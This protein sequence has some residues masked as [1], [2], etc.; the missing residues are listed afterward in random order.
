MKT[1]LLLLSLFLALFCSVSTFGQVNVYMISSTAGDP[2]DATSNTSGMTTVFGSNWSEEYYESVNVSTLLTS[3]TKFIYMDGGANDD[4]YLSSFLSNNLTAIQT[5][6]SNGGHLFLNAAPWNTG[7]NFGF[8]GVTL[9]FNTSYTDAATAGEQVGSNIIFSSPYSP[10]S[11]P[12]SGDYFAHAYISGSGYTTLIEDPATGR[13]LLAQM[14]YGSGIAM[15]GGMTADQ[16]ASPQPGAHYLRMNIFEYLG[17]TCT[18]PSIISQPS[19]VS[20]CP[21]TNTTFS[22]SASGTNTYQ[23]Q[24]NTG[25]GFT[26]ISNAAPYSNATTATLSLT[27]VPSGSSGFQ[28]QCVVTSAC[29]IST[30]S[31]TAALTVTAATAISSQPSSTAVCS[32]TNAAFSVGATGVS[33]SYQWQLSTNNGVSFGNISGATAS[34]YTVPTPN[35]SLDNSQYRVNITGTCGSVTSSSATLRV[36]SITAATVSSQTTCSGT[37][38]VFN[39]SPTSTGPGA[40]SYQW[41]LS[42]VGTFSNISGATSA[43]YTVVSP[44]GTSNNNQYHC[45]VTS[46]SCTSFTSTAGTLTVNASPVFTTCPS[47]MTVSTSTTTCNAVVAYTAIASGTP[48]PTITYSF[49][50]ATSGS[51]SGTGTGST[52]NKGVT[53]VTINAANTCGSATACSFTITVNDNTPPVADAQN[54]I[55]FLDGPSGIAYATAAAVNN[56]SSDNC[57]AAGSLTLS[58]SQT[59]F[60]CPNLGDNVVTLTVTDASGNSSTANATVTVKDVIPPVVRTKNI[61]LN[62]DENTSTTIAS[63]ALDNGSSDNCTIATE[64]I[65]QSMFSCANAGPN[66]VTVTITDESGNVATGTAIVTVNVPVMTVSGNGNAITSGSSTASATNGTDFGSTGI[67]TATTQTYTI[68]NTG[69]NALTIR[70]ISFSGANASDFTV[71]TAPASSVAANGA[72]T[73][74]VTFTPST[75]STESATLLI[76]NFS[77]TTYSYT[78]ALAGTGLA[79][80]TGLNF[81]GDNNYA[82]INNTSLGNFGTSD[83]SVQVNVRYTTT[84]GMFAVSKRG[85]CDPS[86]FW[87]IAFNAGHIYLEV[88]DG[89]TGASI[90]STHTFNDGNW[91]QVSMVRKSGFLTLYVDGVNEASGSGPSNLS[92]GLNLTLGSNPCN[93]LGNGNIR[94][95]GDMD[96]LRIWSRALCTAEIAN[97]KSCELGSGQTGLLAYYKFNEGFVNGNNS[98]VTS[99]TDATG[100][101]N[102]GT[103][104][105]FTLSGSSS[106]WASGNAS[107]TCT[108]F[109]N[110]IVSLTGNSNA[111]ANGAATTSATNLTYFGS[112]GQGTTLT[113]TYSISNT[114]SA[115]LNIGTISFSGTNAAD[116]TVT[117]APSGSVAANSSTTFVVTFKP[118]TGSTENSIISIVTNDCNNNPF[119]FAL[120]GTGLAPAGALN[121]DGNDDFV[122]VPHESNLVVSNALTMEA[123]V[124]PTSNSGWR[125]I[126]NKE[127]DWEMFID[128]GVFEYAISTAGSN[129]W[130]GANVATLPLNTWSHVAV[131]YDGTVAKAYV[132]GT[133]ITTTPRTGTIS[134]S[135]LPYEIG[136]RYSTPSGGPF[137]GNIDEVRIWNRA[138]CQGEIQNSMSCE[139]P[140]IQTGLISY[141]KFDQGFVNG[142]NSTVTTATDASGLGNNGTLENFALTGSTS[143]W[144][145]G[146]VSGTCSTFLNPIASVTGIANNSLTTSTSNGTNFGSTGQ[147]VGT[148]ETYTITN[149]GNATLSIG[150]ISFAG[151]NASDFKVTTNP[152]STVAANGSTTFIVT[153]T[154]TNASVENATISIVTNDCYNDPYTF[155]LSG[156]GLPPAGYLNFSGNNTYDYIL[157]N[158]SLGNVGSGDF[159]I[160]MNVRFTSTSNMYLFSKRS[161]CGGDN[162]L[163]LQVGNGH[164]GFEIDDPADGLGGSGGGTATLNDGNWHQI[165]MTRKSGAIIIYVDG[166]VDVSTNSLANINNSYVSTLGI[167]VCTGQNPSVI[168]TGDMDEVRFW[169][170]A[171]CQGEVQNSMTCELSGTQTGLLAYYK[172]DEGYSTA[173]NSS[174]TSLT[175]ATGNGNTATLNNF[176]LNGSSSNWIAG[177]KFR[178]LRHFCKRGY[179][180]KREQQYDCQWP[181]NSIYFKQYQFRCHYGCK[182]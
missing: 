74:T 125:Q 38:A 147:S 140:G 133:L 58:L 132:N 14:S 131:T 116:F 67:N 46:A 24:V 166:N 164:V 19:S 65:S 1:R 135:Q 139:Y 161:Y 47:N 158:S 68:N 16:F 54:I 84:S 105:S 85:I 23:W 181:S 70:N 61:T 51:G 107:G 167:S 48:A 5:W 149:T 157:L 165:S 62:L 180:F 12:W 109:T 97:N 44:I 20:I 89:I 170:R 182:Y 160:Q 179:R 138:L 175:D 82:S 100:N 141:F 156:T 136:W 86:N 172:F 112:T 15:F 118:M 108:V 72:T 154:P 59:I 169:N 155:A 113:E 39:V 99:L 171:L 37:N 4:T 69:A 34:S 35:G 128:N 110:A 94:Y 124:Y 10:T 17:S 55:I 83:F 63:N 117:T 151:T 152:S 3:N 28:Y 11:S 119:T 178:Y 88:Q 129:S 120:S 52:F 41:Q 123:W 42:T 130:P 90:T 43:S 145:A 32:G 114:G 159:S 56:A 173:N 98:S 115:A 106:N 103:L 176:T 134:N 101:G 78:Y 127:F 122:S 91:H 36:N 87:D 29:S 163:S 26:N 30:T 104:N 25:S 66:T 2:W 9:N 73:F 77:C 31:N 33:L 76:Q 22:V 177:G 150:S 79:P 148:T 142:N 96:E 168:Y 75:T 143:N 40:L 18:S 53:T 95:Q 57:T 126:V 81:S 8:G 144:V 45:L 174:V 102:T 6:V 27:N 7:M 71:T 60:T 50:G 49:S 92:N 162:F 93:Y 146:E 137:A 21:G 121:F 153:F 80:A 111:I 13:T 64:T